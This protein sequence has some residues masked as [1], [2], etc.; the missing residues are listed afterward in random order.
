MTTWKD[1][2]PYV[3][4]L[5][6]TLGKLLGSLTPIPGGGMAGE[7]AG[8]MLARQFGVPAE[9]E[10]IREAIQQQPLPTVEAKLYE[11]EQEADAKWQMLLKQTE[12]V[13]ETIQHET[14]A[15]VAWYHWRH[16]L[17]YVVGAW[18]LAL[19]PPIVW[20]LVRPDPV[21]LALQI[22]V[23]GT[24]TLVLAGASALLGVVAYDTSRFKEAITTGVPRSGIVATAKKAVG[25]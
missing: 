15:K 21:L 14:T 7:W 6:P 20:M 13:N 18:Y 16:L 12:V 25:R 10:A 11:A 3:A 1:L 9:P 5:A 22:Q 8:Q 17:G 19:L 24:I 2:V 4:P 23:L